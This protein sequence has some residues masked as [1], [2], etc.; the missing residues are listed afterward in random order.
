MRADLRCQY[1]TS[2]YL[3]TRWGAHC[4]DSWV[5]WGDC[6]REPHHWLFTSLGSLSPSSHG[7][8]Y[9]SP[10]PQLLPQKKISVPHNGLPF[11][12]MVLAGPPSPNSVLSPQLIGATGISFGANLNERFQIDV[13]GN[14]TTG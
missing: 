7:N 8:V 14:I 11:P 4:Q 6:S 5:L 2:R 3:R 13:V 1:T 10:Y 12:L 9:L